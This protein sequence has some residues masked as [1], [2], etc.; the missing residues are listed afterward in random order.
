MSQLH[1]S[2]NKTSLDVQ[3]IGDFQKI[4][5]LILMTGEQRLQNE[6][7]KYSIK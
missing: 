1:I 2:T 3:N 5:S 4:S 7:E 6:D